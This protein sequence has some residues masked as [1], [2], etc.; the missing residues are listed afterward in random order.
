MKNVVFTEY[1]TRIIRSRYKRAK[2]QKC[3]GLA[4]YSLHCIYRLNS[5]HTVVS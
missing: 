2:Y 1:L 5:R 4:K 3:F